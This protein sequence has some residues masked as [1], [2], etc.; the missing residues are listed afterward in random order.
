LVKEVAKQL[1]NFIEVRALAF[2]FRATYRLSVQK[3]RLA[4]VDPK[5][6]S[7]HVAP[8]GIELRH[9]HIAALEQVS[10]GSWQPR[11]IYSG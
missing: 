6:P 4:P 5:Y 9:I 10:R 3:M 2:E 7:Y 8:G 1:R 11:L